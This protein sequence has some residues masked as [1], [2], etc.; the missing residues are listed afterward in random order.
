MEKNMSFSGKGKFK[1]KNDTNAV[2][3]DI[4]VTHFLKDDN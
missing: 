1:I 2:M 3:E 4:R